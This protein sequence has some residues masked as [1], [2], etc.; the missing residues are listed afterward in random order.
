MHLQR[1]PTLDQVNTPA[2]FGVICK[3]TEGA[4]NPL[5][6][7]IDTD[8]KEDQLADLAIKLN[9]PSVKQHC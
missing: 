5:I 4:L 9:I 2:Q 3:F 8:I 7:I 1:L 6:Q